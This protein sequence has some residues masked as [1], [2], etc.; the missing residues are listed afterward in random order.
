[1]STAT[2]PRIYVGTYHK[3]N[4]GSISGEWL[5]LGDYGSKEEFLKACA[6]LH[7]DEH[8]PELMFQDYEG[9]PAGMVSESHVDEEAW[10]WMKLDEDDQELLAVY[11]EWIDQSGDLEAA[12]ERFEGMHDSPE[13]W[14][15]QF[16]EDTG[17]LK[18]VPSELRYHID[19][20]SYAHDCE[21]DGMSF[22]RHDGD[23]WVFRSC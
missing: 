22:V 19:F 9:I 11:R 14:A 15:E 18:N 17:S 10:E 23:V 4:C 7:E 13:D 2:T 1:M 21:C 20:K 12:R 6:E 16:L 8:D 3:Y 5:S